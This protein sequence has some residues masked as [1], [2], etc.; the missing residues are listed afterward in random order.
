MGGG[1]G[2]A[3]RGSARGAGYPLLVDTMLLSLALQTGVQREQ[4]GGG[5]GRK[6][7]LGREGRQEWGGKRFTH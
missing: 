3:E 1:G 7:G 4:K 2:G 5:E 6:G